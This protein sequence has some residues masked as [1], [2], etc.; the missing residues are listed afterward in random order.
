MDKRFKFIRSENTFE[1]LNDY[2]TSHCLRLKSKSLFYPVQYSLFNEEKAEGGFGLRVKEG[3]F[4]ELLCH[5][6]YGGSIKSSYNENENGSKDMLT[7]EPDIT[8]VKRKTFMEVKG[9]GPGQALKLMDGQIAKYAL[10]QTKEYF[11]KPSKI[12]FEIFRHGVSSIQE[13]YKNKGLEE[14]IKRLSDS[15]R[16]LI[17]LPFS[18]IFKIY[19]NEGKLTSRHD[20]E[21]TYYTLTRLNSTGLNKFIAYP[22]E[23]LKEFNL[24]PNDFEIKKRRLPKKITINGFKINTF[25]MLSIYDKDHEKATG[26]INEKIKSNE[27]ISNLFYSF[28]KGLIGNAPE[29]EDFPGWLSPSDDAPF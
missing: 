2:A 12:R 22:E 24:N 20:D 28:T 21:R 25:P 11:S 16:F 15:V 10:L 26:L 19:L 17:S 18:V 4:F 5:G 6:I 9:V 14:L 3:Y 23:T 8:D 27:R 1:G 7:T 29:Q 13:N